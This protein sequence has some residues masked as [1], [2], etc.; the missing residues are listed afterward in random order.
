MQ[1]TPIGEKF[2]LLHKII[3]L[4]PKGKELTRQGRWAEVLEIVAECEPMVER[5]KEIDP[6]LATSSM[7]PTLA[8]IK[9]HAKA[10]LA[11]QTIN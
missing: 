5:L 9:Q 1:V 3:K 2:E 11:R 10:M 6:K 4:A 7:G 8:N